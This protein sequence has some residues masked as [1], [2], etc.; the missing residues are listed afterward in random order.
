[1]IK[2]CDIFKYYQILVSGVL[3]F[4]RSFLQDTNKILLEKRA[5]MVRGTTTLNQKPIARA[6][7][8]Y[9]RS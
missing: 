4:I 6:E 3:S 5:E 2:T 9:V 1:M 7:S 8:L